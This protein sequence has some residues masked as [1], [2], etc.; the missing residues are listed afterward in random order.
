MGPL[1]RAHQAYDLSKEQHSKAVRDPDGRNPDRSG[2]AYAEDR[3]AFG[4]FWIDTP[5]PKPPRSNR[6]ITP[7]DGQLSLTIYLDSEGLARSQS[8]YYLMMILCVSAKK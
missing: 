2:I 4:L 1:G 8:S 7:L 6:N 3:V 5:I